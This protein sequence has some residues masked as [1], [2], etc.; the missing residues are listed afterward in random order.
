MDSKDIDDVFELEGTNNPEK[1]SSKVEEFDIIDDT[2][3]RD[4]E[5]LEESLVKHSKDEE[6]LITGKHV[7]PWWDDILEQKEGE[8]L[9]NL[10]EIDSDKVITSCDCDCKEKSESNGES[11][12]H[13][14]LEI[15]TNPILDISKNNLFNNEYDTEADI[16]S[17]LNVPLSQDET[18]TKLEDSLLDNQVKPLLELDEILL[19]VRENKKLIVESEEKVESHEEKEELV[20]EKEELVEEK[21]ESEEEKFES[22][23]EKFESEEEKVESEEEKFESEEEKVESEEENVE[24]EEEKEELEEEKVESEEEKEELEEEKVELELK[25]KNDINSNLKLSIPP[26]DEDGSNLLEIENSIFKNCPNLKRVDVPENLESPNTHDK[27]Y[28]FFDVNSPKLKT[29]G[30]ISLRPSIDDSINYDFNYTETK[31]KV[32]KKPWWQFW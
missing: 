29:Q 23:E 14:Y 1:D 16:K 9:E 13:N 7:N 30:K 21:V 5:N 17:P 28:P 11:K 15:G 22:E 6:P 26:I 4:L 10:I 19:D 20:E 24:L 12:V 32:K 3:E 8:I 2:L 25:E 27:S 31:S 18:E